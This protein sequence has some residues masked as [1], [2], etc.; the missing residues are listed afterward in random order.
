MKIAV[1]IRIP[2]YSNINL[3]KKTIKSIL[4]QSFKKY[5]IS[6]IHDNPKTKLSN[7]LD[8]SKI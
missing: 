5:E 3:L 4:S 8:K 6:I 7:L 1:S 2:F